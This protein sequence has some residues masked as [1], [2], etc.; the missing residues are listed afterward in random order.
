[1]FE[2][3]W[4][5]HGRI[6]R[7]QWWMVQLVVTVLTIYLMF[8]GLPGIDNPD[9]GI[10]QALLVLAVSIVSLIINFA[11][12]IKRFHDRGKSG[13]W[14]LLLVLPLIGGVWVFVECGFCT[15]D[16]GDNAY[17]EPPG[18]AARLRALD[19]EVSTMASG[20][21]AKLDDA[22]LSSYAQKLAAAAPVSASV[23]P[24]TAGPRAFGR[25]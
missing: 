9:N 23:G 17:G 8:V 21:M 16:D 18:S 14:S 19:E 2:G 5:T 3:F 11:S 7:L 6:N 25:R 10:G 1:M 22:Y 12:T 4:G 24:G 20:K 15:G 13:W